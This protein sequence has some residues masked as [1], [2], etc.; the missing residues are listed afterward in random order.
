ML[1]PLPQHFTL[2]PCGERE[3]SFGYSPTRA[4]L[5]AHT[6][7]P[8]RRAPRLRADHT[9]VR[10]VTHARDTR[11][12]RAGTSHLCF[13]HRTGSLPSK[14]N[15][16]N[17]AKYFVQFGAT[18]ARYPGASG[19]RELSRACSA[20]SFS[21][22]QLAYANCPPLCMLL[23]RSCTSALLCMPAPTNTV[24]CL[25]LAVHALGISPNMGDY[26]H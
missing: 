10:N 25:P 22:W 2:Q 15:P 8:T 20:Q 12:R 14:L 24:Y 21:W 11:M 18:F 4:A 13:L 9:P 5:A 19:A 26:W 1:T 23:L 7:A 16:G 6:L 17:A 3:S